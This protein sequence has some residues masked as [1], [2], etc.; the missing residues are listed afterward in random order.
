MPKAAPAA[1]GT[2]FEGFADAQMKF[3]HALAKHQDRDW[4]AKH[5]AEYE[6]GWAKP[7]A[8]LL[9]EVAAKLDGA[10]ATVELDAPKVFR[11]HRDVRFSADKSPYKTNVSGVLVAKRGG[12]VT[13]SPAA[14]YVQLGTESFVGAG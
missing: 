4:F 11:L 6:E 3:F 2:R 13:E 7:M 5:K 1:A 9:A 8:A 12:K 14:V 10:Y